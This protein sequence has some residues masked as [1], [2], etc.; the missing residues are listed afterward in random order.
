MWRETLAHGSKERKRKCT[1]PNTVHSFAYGLHHPLE[2]L[3]PR[4]VW[5]TRPLIYTDYGAP[6]RR[7]SKYGLPSLFPP[8]TLRTGR[9]AGCR[10]SSGTHSPRPTSIPADWFYSGIK[11]IPR[12]P[13]RTLIRAVKRFAV[14]RKGAPA[15]ALYSRITALL[16]T[17]PRALDYFNTALHTYEQPVPHACNTRSSVR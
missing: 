4:R 9:S 10:S 15:S 13:R 7:K 12:R 5:F 16:S 11:L 3:L 2:R 1:I 14:R 6:P 8:A 17:A